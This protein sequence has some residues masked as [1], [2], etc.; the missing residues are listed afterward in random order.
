MYH[1]PVLLGAAI[2][3]LA[4][5]ADGIY[6]DAT[7]GGG[8]HARAILGSL[9]K[10][11][12]YAFDQD[13]D[14]EKNLPDDDRITFLN[15]NFRYI[16]NFLRLYA[17]LPVDGV[18]ADLGVSSHQ[19]DQGERG[20]STRLDGPL[21]MRMNQTAPLSART[22]VN[23][24]DSKQLAAVFHSYGELRNASQIAR[25][26][27]KH[28]QANPID[29]TRELVQALSKLAPK[30][31]ENKFFAKVF[32]ALRIEVNQE[33]DALKNFL[34]QCPDILKPG[35]RL[36]VIAY[37][38]LEDRLVKNFI[39]SGNFT[40]EVEKDFYGNPL[41]PLM[42]VGKS[43]VP[44]EEEIQQNPRAR[45]ARLRVAQKVEELRS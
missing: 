3:G 13:G 14:S 36:V 42:P 29:T 22:V 7:F 40:G 4:I 16:K 31:K 44:G 38:S 18:L 34:E 1:E 28:R 27:E 20:F 8:G 19:F 26:I 9:G 24:Y 45:S 5:N 33:L 35:G 17:A 15:Q 12:L 6:V 11:R 39:R 25:Q 23:D 10:G 41:A 37:H 32:Q 43:V 2:E 30:G 21:D